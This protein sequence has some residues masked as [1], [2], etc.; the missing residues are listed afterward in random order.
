[1]S[2]PEDFLSSGEYNLLNY[3]SSCFFA[4]LESDIIL[5]QNLISFY[6]KSVL[7]KKQ[8]FSVPLSEF[9]LYCLVKT[10]V[11]KNEKSLG[12]CKNNDAGV[13]VLYNTESCF[14][15]IGQTYSIEKRFTEH[16]EALSNGFHSN[17]NLRKAVSKDNIEDLVFLIVDYGP[18]FKQKQYRLSKEIEY[19]NRWPGPIYNIKDVNPLSRKISIKR[20]V[21]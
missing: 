3:F 20:N 4:C 17:K 21:E 9:L 14:S 7:E 10:L 5:Y 12:F 6:V 11:W 19:I 15:Y 8:D 2:F 18:P 16:Y 1:M 13:Y